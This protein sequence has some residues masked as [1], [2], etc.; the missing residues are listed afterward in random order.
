MPVPN[1]TIPDPLLLQVSQRIEECSGLHFPSERFADLERGL[2]QAAR[3]SGGRELRDYAESLLSRNLHAA[4]LETLAGALTIGE[5]HFF[6]DRCAFEFL[7]LSLLPELIAAKRSGDR[8]LRIWSAGCATGEEPYSI[9]ILLHYL[10]PD[11]K[12][13][14]ITILGTD[15][16]PKVLAR[17]AAGLY[18]EWAFRDTPDWVK[19]RYFTAR[20]GSRYELHPWLKR[21]VSF[22]C[23][24]LAADVYPSL[25]NSTNALDLIICRNVLLYFAPARIP[26][27]VER[28][29]RALVDGGQLAIG[30]VEASHTTFPGFDAVPA[31]GVALYRKNCR[32]RSAAGELP[33][34]GGVESGISISSV[35]AQARSITPQKAA[36][37]SPFDPPIAPSASRHPP[38]NTPQSL[39]AAGRYQEAR[40]QL[41]AE[42]PNPHSAILLAHCHANL[43]EL[44]EALIWCERALATTKTDPELH[45]LRAAILQELQR[46]EEAL[47]ALRNV[48]FLDP[49]HVLANFTMA[50][51]CRR[52]GQVSAAAKHLARVRQLLTARNES[53]ELPQ[54]GGLTVGQLNAILTATESAEVKNSPPASRN[55]KLRQPH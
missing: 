46:D 51:L 52:R 48:L 20:G 22:A 8:R 54:S 9:A 16:N 23:L 6:R 50:N 13:W 19:L 3:E 7:E 27:I 36:D 4:D 32:V 2:D 29:H 14:H 34:P 10:L 11:L 25:L 28:F 12:N 55:R 5:T 44:T 53:E 47:L 43:G 18:T 41:L 30:A 42:I 33:K 35:A 37:Q 1:R 21:M 15:I 49:A 31:P 45:F 40:A 38:S 39:Y 26:Q 24:N 17:A